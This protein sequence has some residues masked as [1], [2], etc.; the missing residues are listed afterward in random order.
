MSMVNSHIIDV[1]Q[2]GNSVWFTADTHYWHT[3]I[4]KGVSR[5]NDKSGCR[6]F[7]D[8]RTMCNHIVDQF[9]KH[10]MPDDILFHLGDWS[11]SGIQNIWNFRKRL[12]VKNIYLCTGNH[13]QHIKPN[14]ELP[15]AFRE[16]LHSHIVDQ[17]PKE[18]GLQYYKKVYAK[19]LFTGVQ[20]LYE[21]K[22]HGQRITLCH[23][24]MRTWFFHNKGSWMLFGH[25]HDS[26]HPDGKTMDVGIDV[27]K[28]VLGEYRPFKFQ[29]LQK[30]MSKRE[31]VQVDSH[32][33][34]TNA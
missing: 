25:S 1:T 18:V 8:E 28:R 10:V 34:N 20:P 22:V 7:P 17:P 3:N 4:V 31:F 13:D 15:N 24:S 6:D 5:W 16:P 23:Y 27:A 14:K 33:A 32:N 9:N 11:F 19:E 21:I 2:N 12:N 29:E 30:I 26:L